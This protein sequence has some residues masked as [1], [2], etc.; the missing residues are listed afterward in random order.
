MSKGYGSISKSSSSRG[1]RDEEYGILSPPQYDW[2][3]T[4][5]KSTE[6]GYGRGAFLIFLVVLVALAT[7]SYFHVDS[8]FIQHTTSFNLAGG[9]SDGG[10]PGSGIT[11]IIPIIEQTETVVIEKDPN[12]IILTASNEYGVYSQPYTWLQ[13]GSLVEPYKTTT[14]TLSGGSIGSNSYTWTISSSSV[15]DFADQ[16][17][18]S[19]EPTIDIKLTKT[20]TYTLTVTALGQS[21]LTKKLFVKYVKREI[22]S[23]TTEDREK[24]LNAAAVMWNVKTEN[25]RKMYGESYTSADTFVLEH[26]LASNDIRCDSYHEGSGFFTHHFALSNSFEASL[27]VINPEVTLHYWDFSIE[28]QAIADAGAS[29][30]HL[31]NI[32]PVFTGTWFGSVDENDHIQDSRWAHAKM[33]KAPKETKIEPNSFNYIRSYWNNNN[34]EEVTRH[35]FD[36]CGYEPVNKQIPTCRNHFDVLNAA[37]LAKFQTLS[38]ADGH[39]PLH[40]QVGGIGGSCVDGIKSFV[41]RWSDVLHADMTEDELVSLDFDPEVWKWGLTAPRMA[42][43][44][45]EILGEYF[46]IYRSLWRSHMCSRDNTPQLL[47]CPESCDTSQSVDECKCQVQ[48]LVDGTTDYENVYYCIANE[49]SRRDFARLFPKD[50]IVDLVTTISTTSLYEGEMLEAASPADIMFWVIHPTIERLLFAK[51]IPGVTKM[52]PKSFSKWETDGSGEEWLSYSYYTLAEGENKAYPDAYTCYGHGKDDNI[53]PDHFPLLEDF[54]SYADTNKDGS[55]SNWEYFLATNPNDPDGID[56]VFDSYEWSHCD[57]A[58]LGPAPV[59]TS[60]SSDYAD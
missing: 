18:T 15:S 40:V 33:T 1:E 47:Q 56:Y 20:G 14:L 23:L 55:I 59:T 48:S 44:R 32:S 51:R 5:S 22:R 13:E 53:L 39:G 10:G 37:N 16:V 4:N 12:E 50:F 3:I 35:L 29:P 49:H 30:S 19:T 43:F 11:P 41:D 36:V 25:G 24:F 9:R 28:G 52:G 7:V 17:Y 38:P 46:H 60:D 58:M 42:M 45:Q 27:R 8:M 54:A 34:D 31:L 26:S 2:D 57:E 6:S 21:V